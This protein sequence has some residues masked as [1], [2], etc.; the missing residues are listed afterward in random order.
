M[1]PIVIGPPSLVL[2]GS[3]L[4]RSLRQRAVPEG[5]VARSEGCPTVRRFFRHRVRAVHS[6]WQSERSVQQAGLT[7]PARC[8]K[9]IRT[10]GH[11][12][13]GAETPSGV[14]RC[15]GERSTREHERLR[16]RVLRS[17]TAGRAKMRGAN[18]NVWETAK[19]PPLNPYGPLETARERPIFF[20]G[21][22]TA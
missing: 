3:R 14:A 1:A 9:T 10:V 22:L 6:I 18:S 12:S 15:L 11:P 20:P 5:F 4:E 2:S 8:R 7:T 21:F 17:V 19:C 13:L 16:D